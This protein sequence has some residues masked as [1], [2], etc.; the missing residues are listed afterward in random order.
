MNAGAERV[1]TSRKVLHYLKIPV[2]ASAMY[3][4]VQVPWEAGAGNGQR[5]NLMNLAAASI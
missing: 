4:D 1:L 2:I 5:S 3:M